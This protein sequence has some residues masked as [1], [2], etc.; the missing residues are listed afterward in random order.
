VSTAYAADWRRPGTRPLG[1]GVNQH[2]LSTR[3]ARRL[4]G[5]LAASGLLGNAAMSD[6]AAAAV[7][8]GRCRLVTPYLRRSLPESLHA[9]DAPGSADARRRCRPPRRRPCRPAVDRAGVGMCA[10]LGGLLAVVFVCPRGVQLRGNVG[11]PAWPGGGFRENATRC[12]GLTTLL[13]SCWCSARAVGGGRP[14]PAVRVFLIG[15]CCHPD[16]VPDAGLHRPGS[17]RWPLCCW[18]AA[19]C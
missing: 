18:S 9:P 10:A 17:A 19:R 12:S 4:A 1:G 3:A 11:R 5:Q 16:G 13:G 6:W 7:R 8:V 14:V 15:G 2:M